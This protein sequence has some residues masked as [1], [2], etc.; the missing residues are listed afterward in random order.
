MLSQRE[1]DE[2]EEEGTKIFPA[3]SSREV[4]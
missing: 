3:L 4:N 2:E 1:E